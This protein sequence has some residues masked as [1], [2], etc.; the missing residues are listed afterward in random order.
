MRW[1][2]A[3]GRRDASSPPARRAGAPDCA[4]DTERRL[5]AAILANIAEGI[6][7][8][9]ARDGVMVY[10]NATWQRMF[11]YAS[12]EAVG[13]H[14]SAVTVPGDRR[15]DDIVGGLERDGEW[16]GEIENVRKDGTRF[17]SAANISCFE[18]PEHGTVWIAVHS[19][20]TERKAAELALVEAEERFRTVFEEGPVGIVLLDREGRLVEGNDSFS[21]MI[22][23]GRDEIIGLTLEDLTHPEDRGLDTDLAARVRSGELRRYRVVKRLVTKAAEPVPVAITATMVRDPSGR[24]RYGLAIVEDASARRA[25]VS[26]PDSAG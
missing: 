9:R 25:A 18:H 24:P 12:G 22:G 5:Q 17:W 6:A 13:Q 4:P 26:V 8:I 16:R 21:S 2:L 14:V 11:G 20:V 10:V 3:P 23:Y 7:L 1:P 19:D 15:A